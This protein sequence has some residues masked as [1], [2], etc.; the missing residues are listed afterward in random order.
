MSDVRKIHQFFFD[1]DGK[2]LHD[3]PIFVESQM[4]FKSQVGWRYRLWNSKN[5]KKMCRKFFPKLWPRYKQMLPIQQ[6]DTGKYLVAHLLGGVVAD[7]D[8]LIRCNLEKIVGC[9]PYVFD[10]CSRF[11]VIANDFFYVGLERLFWANGR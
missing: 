10:R 2:T 4:L 9:K 5:V 7:L 8:V 6:V 3:Y 1:F 11:G